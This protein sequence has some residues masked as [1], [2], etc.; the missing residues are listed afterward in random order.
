MEEEFVAIGTEPFKERGK[1]TDEYLNI[2]KE[3]WTE[4]LPSYAGKY[5]SFKNIKFE[6]KPIQKPHP[7][8]WIG[9]ESPAAKRRA[10]KLGDGWFP[11]GA[12]PNFPLNT[13]AKYANGLSSLKQIAAEADRNPESLDLGF[14]S[15]WD[16]EVKDRKTPQEGE[17]HI[18]TGGSDAIED[19]INAMRDLGVEIFMF[20]LAKPESL[21]ATLASMDRFS[22]QILSKF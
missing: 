22:D 19:D 6:P 18:M 14:W 1:V 17:R 4:S 16:H 8:L 10:V 5:N 11:I 3:L 15:N 2:F 13:A 7:P 21:E 9:G 20:Q 12:N